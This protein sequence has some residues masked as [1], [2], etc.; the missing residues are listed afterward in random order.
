MIKSIESGIRLALSDARD[1][2]QLPPEFEVVWADTGSDPA[3]AVSELQAM[4]AERDVK[5]V[6]GGATSGE[7]IAMIPELEEHGVVCLSPSAS[8]PGLA[9]KS[10]L[11]FRIYPSDVVEGT[12][13]ADFMLNVMEKSRIMILAIAANRAEGT[14]A[15]GSTCLASLSSVVV[16]VKLTA[17]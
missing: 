11:F 8:A 16:I 15:P 6:I 14:G 12:M 9:K 5:M 4:V 17:A 7:A 2:G 3:A 1:Q 10:R 13:M